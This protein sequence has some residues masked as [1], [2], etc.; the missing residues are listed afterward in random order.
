MSPVQPWHFIRPD[1]TFRLEDPQRSSY[2]YFPLVNA[3]GMI[4]VVTPTLHGDAKTG[5]HAFLLAPT[6]V[7]DLHASRA[8]RNFW[9][10]VEGA[11]PWSAAGAS[12]AQVA[13]AG[14][15]DEDQVSLEAGFLW[16][17][18]TRLNRRT[19]LQ[20]EITSFVPPTPDTVELMQVTLT[21]TSAQPLAL[22]PTAAIPIYA[23]SADNLRD[24]RHV[25]SLLHRTRCGSHGVLVRPALTF[26][27]RGHQPNATTYAVLGAEGDGRPPV[28]F[29]PVLEDFVGEGGTLDWPAAVT[30]AG[31]SAVPCQVPGASVDGYEAMGGLRFIRRVLTP[32]QSHTY[33]IVLGVIPASERSAGPDWGE[34]TLVQAYLNPD[35]F[36]QH[37]TALRD[38]W[39]GKLSALDVT[40]AD[41][42]FDGWLKW[43]TV[44]PILRRMLGNSFLPYHDYGR[45]GRGWRDLWQ[46][47]LALLMLESE[48]A[49]GDASLD[50]LLEGNF[51]GVRLDGSNATIIGS[52]PGEFKADRNNI[53][54]VWMD[55]GLW[56]LLTTELYIDQT[57]DLAFLLRSQVYF[58]DA[59]VQR[60]RAI[61]PEWE[62]AQ[63]TLQLSAGGEVY[64]GT[65]LEHLLVQHLTAFF[66]VGEHNNILLEGADWNDGMDMA[67][68]RGESVAF[69]CFY[70]SNLAHLSHLVLQLERLGVSQVELSVEL[71]ALLDTL[72]TPIDY[73]SHIEKRAYLAGYF[74]AITHALSGTKVS[75]P[76]ARLAADLQAKADWMIA[77]LRAEEWIETRQGYGWFNGYYDDDGQRL[78]GETPDGVRMT[79]TGQVFALMGGIASDEQARQIVRSA[80]HF[81]FDP[82]VGG[83]RLNTDFGQV[84]LNMGRSF[85]FAYGHKE[86]GSMFSHMAVMYAYAL[87]QRGFV[88][89]GY[90]TLDRIY[91]QA[92]H[93]ESSRMYPGIP[94][95]FSP[96]GRG[97]YPYLTGSASWY[98]LTLVTEAFGVRGV[99]GD[100][101]LAPRLVRE[102][103]DAS[104]QAA[105]TTTFA[106]RRL[107]VV[108]HN[109]ARLDWDAYH[110]LAVRL[111]GQPILGASGSQALLPR[112][113]ITVLPP[114]HPHRIDVDLA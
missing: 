19:G 77:H 1:G 38:Y 110:I 2:L 53:P 82:Q 51:G 52:R 60:C 83:Y 32:G 97:M 68:S 87:Y 76:L 105:L 27:E 71:A 81:L 8:G 111:N 88:R 41:S 85:G 9:V 74:I 6:S 31:G 113:L 84:L 24:H 103:F 114:D 21:N 72:H 55:H 45:G 11:G 69:T 65:I 59:H 14:Q 70:A 33:L 98:L 15:P 34:A 66:N 108:Y 22:I 7:E 58:K 102:Q 17:R 28:G 106:G 46:D 79:L 12:A 49:A 40:S 16:Q 44:Q 104:G 5:Q 37:F 23:R 26:D 36:K 86:N 109:P 54:R 39:Q 91:R 92:G 107:Q 80:D 18:L 94:E 73:D 67:R 50:Q 20:A 78:E 90:Q 25:T 112:S 30:A 100:L 99:A 3:A 4:S 10:D 13:Q 43:V 48:A 57:G 29:F 101:E 89:E 63:G 47:N 95:Y 61:D 96:R 93:F 62:P 42:R 56:P 35:N 64:R 75:V